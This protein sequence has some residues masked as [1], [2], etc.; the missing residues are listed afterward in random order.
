M[1]NTKYND[2]RTVAPV[3]TPAKECAEI[4]RGQS[5][6]IGRVRGRGRD[7]VTL[8]RDRLSF[9]IF[10]QNKSPLVHHEDLEKNV[11]VENAKEVGE[12]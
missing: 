3:N 9:K 5:R 8:A 1:F 2:V 4:G 12:K 11:E 10:P 7:R 6:A